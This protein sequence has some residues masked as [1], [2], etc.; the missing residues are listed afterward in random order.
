MSRDQSEGMEWADG[1]QRLLLI[2]GGA[3][4]G[5][6]L[7]GNYVALPGYLRFL[8]RGGTSSAGNEFDFA[9]LIG[10]T[11]T[12]LWMYSFQL[13]VLCLALHHARKNHLLTRALALGCF[14]WLGLWSWP[15][16]PAPGPIFYIVFGSILLISIGV[17]FAAKVAA[18]NDRVTRTLFLAALIFF[19]FATWEVC[20]LGSTGRMLHPDEAAAPIPHNLLVTQSSKHMVEFVLT[21]GLLS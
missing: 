12:I 9:V 10:A 11:K 15:S 2:L 7:L 21:W 18:Y 4:L 13:G 6:A 14:I 17:V 5:Y 20:G 19:A 3:F 16:L 8:E 1:S